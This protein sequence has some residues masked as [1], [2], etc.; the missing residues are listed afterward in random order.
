MADEKREQTP[1]EKA[2]AAKVVADQDKA[3]A[4]GASL[5]NLIVDGTPVAVPKGTMVIEAAFR[6]G[7]DIPYF[8]YHPRLSSVGACRM[9]LASV[10]LEMFGQRRAS[11]MATCTIPCSEGMVVKTQTP[12]VKK[13]QN[14]ILELLLANHP[15]DCPICDRGGECPLQN[16]TISYGPPTSRFTEEKRH[17]PKAKEISDFVVLD[18]ERC[19][20]CMRCTRFADEIA[21]DGKLDL[22]NRG[23]NSE[24]GPFMGQKFDSNFSGNTIEICPVG[25]LTSKS[26]RFKG[27]PW[28]V[29]SVDSVCSKC[30]N[31][32]NIA[33]GHRL[34]EVVRINGRTNED[35]NE[36]WTC[37]KGKFGQ[38]YVNS[39]ER[40]TTP[41]VRDLNGVLQPAS[42][43][44]ALTKIAGALK[45][46][47]PEQIG[48]IGSTRATLEDNYLFVKL[49][50]SVVGTANIDHQLHDY[51]F[52][53]MQ[54]SI[55]DLENYKKIVSVGM[56]L[57]IDQPIVYLRVY[58]AVRRKKA[59]WVQAATVAEAIE[60]LD[61][62]SV[63]LLPHTLS[64]ADY[65]VAKSACEKVGAKFNLLLPDC[66]SWGA[67][68]AGVQPGKNGRNTSGIFSGDLKLLYILG[69]DPVVRYHDPA[70]AREAIVKA[71][72]VVVQELF[73]TETA[74]LATIVLPAAS[75]VEK[76]GTFVNIEGREQ[77]IK[78]AL[79]PRS[80]SRPD[81]RIF[82]DL[83]ARLGAPAPYFSARDIYREWQKATK[84]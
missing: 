68:Q 24:I 11:L 19:I 12:D 84:S 74:K 39:E 5:V 54:T 78:Q 41:L 37:D 50:K 33:V 15:L 64:Q 48:G 47:K 40:L 83:L 3:A 44:V 13:A 45:H 73:L 16:M 80:G 61:A 52:I 63:L 8:C 59:V 70:K 20:T 28:E 29:K 57:D 34:G 10:E 77:K 66:N 25:A 14:G 71:E 43:D 72:F 35:I 76:D 2:E 69:S 49:L 81:W 79:E 23:A 7:S 62:E 51:P 58:K 42:W 38:S 27:R 46:F 56:K 82:S 9:C 6:A 55:A 1:Q 21:G 17:Y 36:E 30:G 26:Y 18:R 65:A 67:V 4:A 60:K 32:C 75:F 22:I 53:P 31:G